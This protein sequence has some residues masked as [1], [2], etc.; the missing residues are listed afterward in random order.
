MASLPPQLGSIPG[1]PTT[2]HN[3]G[4]VAQRV[5][6]RA[7]GRALFVRFGY[8]VSDG[9]LTPKT[10]SKEPVLL[11]LAPVEFVRRAPLIHQDFVSFWF[12]F[13]AAILTRRVSR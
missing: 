3:S 2:N 5:F 13:H 8:R 10:G 11:H 6:N 1:A 12:V 4:S 9:G 7:R